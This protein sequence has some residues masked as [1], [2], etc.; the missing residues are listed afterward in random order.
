MSEK[1]IGPE[2]W[3]RIDL[4][5]LEYVLEQQK[6]LNAYDLI[7]TEL[8]LDDKV[9]RCNLIFGKMVRAASD[10]RITELIN[11]SSFAYFDEIIGKFYTQGI[12]SRRGIANS[13]E[14][15]CMLLQGRLPNL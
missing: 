9:A 15:L 10:V 3:T 7:K 6:P 5:Y 14:N 11:V 4:E 13:V 1:E 12:P 2:I 8:V